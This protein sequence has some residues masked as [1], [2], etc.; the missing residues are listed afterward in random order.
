M[1]P[2]VHLFTH[3]SIHINRIRMSVCMF[4]CLCVCPGQTFAE[5]ERAHK[6]CLVEVQFIG[7]CFYLYLESIRP[8]VWTLLSKNRT[9]VEKND[10]KSTFL[11]VFEEVKDLPNEL[12]T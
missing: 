6:R 2:S 10:K 7:K 12:S 5:L 1:A 4:V 9:T 8:T 3:L 11:E